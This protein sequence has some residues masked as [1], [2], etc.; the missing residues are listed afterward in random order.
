MRLL[1]I[2]AC[3][4]VL[5]PAAVHGQA[6]RGAPAG[7]KKDI[8]YQ[9]NDA[10]AKLVALVNAMPPA[11]FKWR[12][13]AEVRSVSEVLVHVA[14]EN[15]QIPPLAGATASETKVPADAEKSLTDRTAVLDFF[16]K[17][18][19]YARQSVTALPDSQMDDTANYFNTPMSKRGIHIT[20]ATHGHEHLGQLIAYA[21]ANQIKPPW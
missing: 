6:G 1:R 11:L 19:A 4:V 18:F 13:N 21:R 8:I 17:S 20:V 15:F 12:P 7:V 10:E 5:V 9:L 3:A 14:I 2:A 16:R